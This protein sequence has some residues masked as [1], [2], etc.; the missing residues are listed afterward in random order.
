MELRAEK[1][2]VTAVSTP[3]L[4]VNLY[5]GVEKPGGATGSVDEALGGQMP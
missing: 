2:D 1:A 3:A 5:A 4:V